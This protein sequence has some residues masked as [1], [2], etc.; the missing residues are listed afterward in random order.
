MT[1][2]TL[3]IV[4][5]ACAAAMACGLSVAALFAALRERYRT[6][7]DT[8]LRA[9]YLHGLMLALENNGRQI[10]YFPLFGHYGTRRLLCE[11]VAGVVALTYGLDSGRLRHVVEHYS[12]DRWMLRHARRRRGFRRAHALAVLSCLSSDERMAVSVEPYLRSR[13]RYV[14]FYALAVQLSVDPAHALHR[15]GGYSGVLSAS[16]VSELMALLR[17]GILPLAYGPLLE[18]R[19]ANLRRVGLAIV[20]QFGIE[21]AEGRLLQFVADT[22]DPDL[23]REALYALCSL[24]R[25]LLR[26]EVAVYIVGM[27]DRARRAL[28]RCMALEGYALRTMQRLFDEDERPYYETLVRSYKRSL[29]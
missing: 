17:R 12:L 25:S 8:I 28:L 22:S 18:A 13:N 23:G 19:P 27:D 15:I 24:R 14:R 10:P 16:E 6:G 5:T 7:H 29:A 4:Y 9:K 2:D 26:R 21:E 1:T 20:R 11:A 3:Y